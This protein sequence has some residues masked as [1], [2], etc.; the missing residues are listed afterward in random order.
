M[1]CGVEVPGKDQTQQGGWEN[2]ELLGKRRLGLL[3]GPM[4]V[5]LQGE[6]KLVIQI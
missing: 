2:C 6:Q 1:C 4:K 5:I 3:H